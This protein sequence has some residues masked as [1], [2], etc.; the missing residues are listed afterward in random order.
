MK[1]HDADKLLLLASI[2]KMAADPGKYAVKS[3]RD[4]T[5]NRKLGFHDII[6][7]LLTMEADCI[8]EEFYRYFGRTT[9]A[10]LK[11]AFYK[12][13]K[14]LPTDTLANLFCMF[15]SKLPEN[16]ITGSIGSLPA[17]A[18]LL[19]FFATLTTRI[20]SLNLMTNSQEALTR[21]ISMLS[22]QSLTGIFTNLVVQPSE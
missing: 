5:R 4:F 22:T 17:M 21:S 18:L 10:T 11:A 7:M 12:Q 2:D 6:Q 13:R 1:K 19:I 9:N 3:G 8:K 14:K 16:S 15:S 20:L